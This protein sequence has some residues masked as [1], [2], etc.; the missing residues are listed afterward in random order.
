MTEWLI[1]LKGHH[2]DLD[3]LS[4]IMH[5]TNFDVKKDGDE[6]YLQATVFDSFTDSREVYEYAKTLI[7]VMN[8]VAR[9]RVSGFKNVSID[10]IIQIDSQGDRKYF[11]FGSL[12]AVLDSVRLQSTGTVSGTQGEVARQPNVFE[13]WIILAEQ[14]EDVSDALNYFAYEQPDWF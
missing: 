6:Y 7:R 9:V 10:S 13:G 2:Y 1:K 14:D 5:L 11:V 4:A 8:G 3:D 12:N